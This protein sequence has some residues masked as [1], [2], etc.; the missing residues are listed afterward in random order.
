[1]DE[2]I[3]VLEK[4]VSSSQTDQNEAA[5]FIQEYVARDFTGFLQALSDVLYNQQNPP[6]VRAAAGL[7]LKNQLTARDDVL[8]QQQQ[9]RWLN[10]PE[11]T[12]LHIKERVFKA[13]GTEIFRPSS[14]PQCV[15][16]IAVIELPGEQWPGLIQALASNVTNRES[17]QQL[18][19]ASLETIA[20]ICQDID[21]TCIQVSDSNHILNAIVNYGMKDDEIDDIKRAATTAL[22]NLLDAKIQKMSKTN[23]TI[24]F[25]KLGEHLNIEPQYAERVVAQMIRDERIQGHLNQIEGTVHF[26]SKDVLQ[27]FDEE[28]LKLCSEVNDIIEKIKNVVPDEWWAAN[29]HQAA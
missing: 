22:M 20:Y 26:D 9:E 17:S 21:Q 10:L 6:V 2:L 28:I 25:A 13:L 12:K 19:L 24:S 8:K 3:K 23:Q 1:M 11:Q 16:Y 7:Q 15:A 14:A 29:A 5:R 27:L 18:R 4:T